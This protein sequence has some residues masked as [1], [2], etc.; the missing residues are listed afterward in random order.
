MAALALLPSS[1]LWQK[2]WPW[3]QETD[4]KCYATQLKWP[5]I[6]IITPSYNQ[7]TYLEET[8]RSILLQNYP[9]LEFLVMDGGS[10]DESLKIIKKYAP[11]I[12]YWVSEKDG[13]QSDAINKGLEKATGDVVNWINS[14]DF[15]AKDALFHIGKAFLDNP[16]ID[17]V[18]GKAEIFGADIAR[19]IL[20]VSPINDELAN[21]YS[22]P[23]PQMSS[24]YRLALVRSLGG[25]DSSFRFSM[26]YDLF[27]R[28]FLAG[29]MLDI[30]ALI[31]CFRMHPASKTNTLDSIRLGDDKVVFSRLLNTFKYQGPI[32]LFREIGFYVQNQSYYVTH[33]SFAEG[34]ICD[35]LYLFLRTRI[36]DLKELENELVFFSLLQLLKNSGN[37]KYF[38]THISALYRKYFAK[39][40][41]RLPLSVL[42]ICF[43]K[44]LKEV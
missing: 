5:R 34:D 4:P 42:R 11:W 8:I 9:N 44:Q 21:L 39:L 16:G 24:F 10:N 12:N 20:N 2:N 43:T 31:A 36:Y 35:C 30:D 23:H 26:D 17:F 28:I 14:D 38:D 7:G 13:G 1:E 37:S 29:S 22:F 32:R 15:L 33:R 3:N 18:C 40:I 25:I 19:E 6:T 27:V 41:F